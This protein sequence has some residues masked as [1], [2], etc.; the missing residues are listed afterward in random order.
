MEVIKHLETVSKANEGITLIH[1]Y[2][3]THTYIYIYIYIYIYCS[4]VNESTDTVVAE[5]NK[6]N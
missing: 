6:L 3:H 1:I 5:L 4:G 2:T